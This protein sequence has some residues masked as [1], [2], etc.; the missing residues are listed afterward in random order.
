MPIHSFK[1]A[2][3]RLERERQRAA[4]ESAIGSDSRIVR[5]CPPINGALQAELEF[6]DSTLAADMSSVPPM[7]DHNG[8]LIEVRSH[9]PFDLHTLAPEGE[10]KAGPPAELIISGLTPTGIQLQVEK[11][12]RYEIEGKTRS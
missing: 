3:Q 10:E 7:R 6:L 4:A 5:P 8:K 9:I 12:I 1:D 11:H 2:E